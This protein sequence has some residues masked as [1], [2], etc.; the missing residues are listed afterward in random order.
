MGES[1]VGTVV[2]TCIVQP[3]QLLIIVQHERQILITD[4]HIWVTAQPPVFLLCLPSAA[5]PMLVDLIFNLVRSI[6]HEDARIRI[7]S[8]HFCLGTL[9]R[10][11]EF[12]VN[13]SRFGIFEL[14]SYVSRQTE[15]WI[16]VDRAWDK[17]GYV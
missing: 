12:G 9:Q 14:R 4:I 10:R 1:G 13:Q 17:A 2:D 5:E 16:L 11:K 6:R 3:R 15:V 7:R 8:A